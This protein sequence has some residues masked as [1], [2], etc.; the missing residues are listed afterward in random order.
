MS[1]RRTLDR[2]IAVPLPAEGAAASAQINAGGATDPAPDLMAFG[3]S[4]SSVPAAARTGQ[5][6]PPTGQRDILADLE[7]LAPTV[8]LM[9][10]DPT[11][12]APNPEDL[13]FLSGSG[14]GEMRL[15]SI[16][17]DEITCGS[18]GLGLYYLCNTI[19]DWL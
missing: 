19:D 13:S 3:A 11:I 5:P 18:S 2:L 7:T 14:H 1:E 10:S 6:I 17:Q 4:S 16:S 9:D 15:V 8:S 12:L